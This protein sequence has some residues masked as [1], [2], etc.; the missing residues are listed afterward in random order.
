MLRLVYVSSTP[1]SSNPRRPINACTLAPW[2][3]QAPPEARATPRFEEAY[4]LAI[5]AD[6]AR[7]PLD[8]GYRLYWVGSDTLGSRDVGANAS[9]IVGRHTNSDVVLAGDPSNSLR[10]LLV[11]ATL[12][13][14]GAPVLRVLDL[15]TAVGFDLS[16]GTFARSIVASGP[17][18]FRVGLHTLVALPAGTSLPDAL[19]EPTCERAE[20]PRPV[21]PLPAALARSAASHSRVTLQP[22]A[23]FV[24]E[25]LTF[26]GSAAD[27]AITLSS[28]R[29]RARVFLSNRD[30]ES[31]VLI[32]RANQCVDG[33][34]RSVLGNEISR[35]HLLLLR[36]RGVTTAF[37]TASTQGS[38]LEGRRLR[39][40]EMKDGATLT[41]A[42]SSPVH[43]AWHEP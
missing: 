18:A 30:L 36:D 5:A 6:R 10:H 2:Q 21:V 41:L 39:A 19:P 31:G 14:D 4:A 37:D 38:Y 1:S 12:L 24:T 27:C 33:G 17:V 11:R 16:D 43:L 8:A 32:G 20:E 23:R 3:M 7:P 26:S 15:R 34:L 22:A 42:A 25:R 28:A 13:D 29:G 35:V 9:V 40:S